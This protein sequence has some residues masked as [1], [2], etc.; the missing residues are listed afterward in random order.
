[1]RALSAAELLDVWER[2]LAQAPAVR[3]LTLLGAASDAPPDSLATLSIGERD[4]LLLTLRE[5][6]FGS[7][8]LCIASCARCGE[9]LELSMKA[10]D[11]HVA[12]AGPSDFTLSMDGYEVDF[13][14]PNSHDLEAIAN[15][16]DL[17]AG[18]LL[19][20]QRCLNKIDRTGE[21]VSAEQVPDVVIEALS[22]RMEQS[23]PQANLELT[24]TCPLCD[25]EWQRVFD[26]ETFFWK[27]IGAWASR[28]LNEI[29]T[30]ASAYGW[31]E[32]DLLN[33]TPWRR[34]VYLNLISQ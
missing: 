3:A 12:P 1:M 31:S 16:R 26:I 10:A 11:L 9:N 15:C 8:L 14:V 2:G 22:E 33:M 6:L 23:D 21:S 13:R 25:H 18:Q 17:T 19:L 27:E 24:L 32:I 29:H 28:L 20:L 5:W 30:L 4:G 34:Q 7:E